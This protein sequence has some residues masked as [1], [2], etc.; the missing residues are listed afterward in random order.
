MQRG[1]DTKGDRMS[2]KSWSETPASPHC[3]A[4]LGM[5]K[6][7]YR[8]LRRR[9]ASILPH[10]PCTRRVAREMLL[11]DRMSQSKCPTVALFF[12]LATYKSAVHPTNS[13]DR[14][15]LRIPGKARIPKLS[16]KHSKYST[17]YKMNAYAPEKKPASSV[18]FETP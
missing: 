11:L 16:P 13:P 1:T 3:K 9:G 7:F 6:Y 14:E 10:F 5:L 12:Q 4:M 17:T 18:T 8:R 2:P 15:L